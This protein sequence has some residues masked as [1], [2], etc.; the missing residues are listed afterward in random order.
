M[1]IFIAWLDERRER[2]GPAH[3]LSWHFAPCPGGQRR[4]ARGNRPP[5]S[6]PAAAHQSRPAPPARNARRRP[7]PARRESA[8][9]GGEAAARPAIAPAASKTPVLSPA[10]PVARRASSTTAAADPWH[11]SPAAQGQTRAASRRRQRAQ[12]GFRRP[13]ARD[14]AR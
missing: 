14:R 2:D 12:A 13:A 7:R 8:P 5:R 3:V 6:P 9:A 10:P 11:T 1:P 4:T